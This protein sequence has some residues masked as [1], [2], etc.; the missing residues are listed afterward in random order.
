MKRWI[1]VFCVLAAGIVPRGA[2]GETADKALAA[3]FRA[4]CMRIYK[5]SPDSLAVR[6]EDGW[7]FLRKELRHIAVGTFWGDRAIEVSRSTK[8]DQADPLE[9][10]VEY[11][12]QCRDNNIELIV[13]PIPPKAMIYPEAIAGEVIPAGFAANPVRLDAAHQQFYRLLQD[14]GVTVLDPTDVFLERRAGG[15]ERMYCRQD[16][17]FS[18][19]A[20]I[21]LGKV[22]AER[23]RAAPWCAKVPKQHISA[24]TETIEIDGD[25]REAFE[26]DKVPRETVT[27]RKVKHDGLPIMDDP[28]S[29]VLLMGDSHTLVFHAGGDMHARASGLADQ[30]ACELKFGVDV[31]GVR[32]SGARTARV[33]LYRRARN[34]NYLAGKKLI[35]WCFAARDLTESSGWG[36]VPLKP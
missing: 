18:G 2:G 25:L 12:K 24:G 22:L 10:I 21:V 28:D 15:S 32:G 14:R 29:P 3:G 16:S 23:V 19:K 34:G 1:Y 13:L 8:P 4:H 26:D 5:A 20:C 33:S 6:G 31:I 30:L 11:N 36:V 9:A 27:V 17:H 35:I 7:L